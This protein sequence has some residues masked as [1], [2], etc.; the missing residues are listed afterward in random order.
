V[1]SG[2]LFLKFTNAAL[3]G[4]FYSLKKNSIPYGNLY[5]Q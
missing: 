2:G 4:K 1:T 3:K 5:E